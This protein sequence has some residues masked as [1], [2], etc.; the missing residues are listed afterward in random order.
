[1]YAW[2]VAWNGILSLWQHE[3][4]RH[5]HIVVVVVVIVMCVVC[6]VLHF[7]SKTAEAT[8]VTS[9]AGIPVAAVRAGAPSFTLRYAAHSVLPMTLAMMH[10]Y[11]RV[12]HICL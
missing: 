7:Q 3:R 8:Q 4:Q 11:L 12:T 10:T 5:H 2:L 9:S 1:M 6:S